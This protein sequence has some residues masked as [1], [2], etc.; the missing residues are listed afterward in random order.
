MSAIQRHAVRAA[1]IGVFDSGVGGLTVLRALVRNLPA[2]DSSTSATRRG[3]RR[4]QEPANRSPAT[5]C[6]RRACCAIAASSA[7]SSRA[8]PRRPSR[9]TELAREFAGAGARRRRAGAAAAC[10][11]PRDGRI[12]VIATEARSAGAP[13][14]ARSAPAAARPSSGP[15]ARCSSRS[16]RRAGLRARSSSAVAHRY[17]DDLFGPAVGAAAGPDTLVLGCTHFP[18]LAPALR[19]RVLGPGGV[20]IV[21]SA[22]TTAA[23]LADVV[24][25]GRVAR[26]RSGSR[27]YQPG[28]DRRSGAL[29]ARGRH[30]PRP[31]PSPRPT[32]RSW[33]SPARPARVP[34]GDAM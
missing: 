16:R 32:S 26:H 13:T 30:L 8:I 18:V 20:A 4:H 19:A 22:E 27:A 33:T 29:C 9:S 31:A 7:W 24:G 15:R 10:R 28:G 17:L 34:R 1:P 12:A 5:R 14:G 6:R 21:D 3:C 2:E 25:E 23:A 11:D